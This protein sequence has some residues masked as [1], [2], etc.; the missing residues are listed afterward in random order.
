M[1]QETLTW[2]SWMK[3]KAQPRLQNVE[4]YATKCACASTDSIEE[5]FPN[6]QCLVKSD[7]RGRY[8]NIVESCAT[9]LSQAISGL[10]CFTLDGI[11]SVKSEASRTLSSILSAF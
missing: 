11:N 4:R 7:P 6:Q 5:G 9:R 10:G 8:N 2:Q 3:G 1:K